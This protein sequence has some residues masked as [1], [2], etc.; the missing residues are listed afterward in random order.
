MFHAVIESQQSR[1]PRPAACGWSF[2]RLASSGSARTLLRGIFIASS[3]IPIGK[4]RTRV[5]SGRPA[6]IAL[7]RASQGPMYS[8]LTSI[9]TQPEGRLTGE[10]GTLGNATAS[11]FVA[12]GNSSR[13][14]GASQLAAQLAA[15]RSG[16]STIQRR[17][18]HAIVHT[19][20][21]LGAS[22]ECRLWIRRHR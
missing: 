20:V 12:S 10:G 13:P 6:R 9:K 17:R 8:A 19:C 3:T 15:R 11:D 4:R 21:G 7:L 1:R 18:R 16:L 2:L 5:I 14:L 22:G